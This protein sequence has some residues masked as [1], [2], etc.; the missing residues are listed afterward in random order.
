MSRD[1]VHLQGRD[2]GGIVWRGEEVWII[3][4]LNWDVDGRPAMICRQVADIRDELAARL[5]E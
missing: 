3:C 4:I 1:G 5:Q 2:G